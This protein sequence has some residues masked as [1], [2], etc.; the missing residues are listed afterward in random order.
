MIL[1]TCGPM[2]AG[3]S[4]KQGLLW[5]SVR[6][7]PLICPSGSILSPKTWTAWAIALRQESSV[8][9]WS[10]RPTSGTD[11][12]GL[13]LPTPMAARSGRDRGGAN[14]DGPER[15]SLRQMARIGMLPTPNAEE[16]A[17]GYVRG[18]GER[19][20]SLHGAARAG[21]LGAMLPTPTEGDSKG[22]GSR[23]TASS[24]AHS[25]TSLTDAVTGSNAA[26]AHGTGGKLHPRFVEWM[27]GWPTGW[28]A[29]EPVAMES[30]RSWLRALLSA[31]SE[32]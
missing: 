2:F 30:F 25:G 20:W 7:S 13:Q 15:P 24:K 26:R 1:D 23:C 8:R 32:S 29:C 17:T 31:C 14:P 19:T 10:G 12:S 16:R 4:P 11:S 27:M 9:R 6:T 21:V 28:T 22:S 18:N 5:S 3:S